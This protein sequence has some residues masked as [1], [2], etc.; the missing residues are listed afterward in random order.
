[1]RRLHPV[2]RLV[3]AAGVEALRSRRG[4]S[5]LPPFDPASRL[6]TDDPATSPNSSRSDWTRERPVFSS[7]IP[8]FPALAALLLS[9][10]T[11]FADV[12][13]TQSPFDGWNDAVHLDNGKVETVVVPSIG[14]VM[15]FRLKA[16][17]NVFWENE[18]MRG[19]GMPANP[20]ST[21]G[22]F[23]GDK[24][25]PS[26]QSVWNWPPPDIFDATPLSVEIHGKSVELNSP[27]SPRFGIRT[28]RVIELDPSLPKMRIVTTYYKE[29]GPPVEVGV[30]IITQAREP[31]KVF[32]PIPANGIFPSGLAS[33]WELPAKF[34]KIE[35]GMVSLSR[36]PGGSHKIGNDAGSIAWVGKDCV[37]RIDAPRTPGAKYPD[38]GCSMELYTNLDPARYVELETLGPLK[39]MKP[40]DTL[41]ATN[42]YTL[43]QRTE[44]DPA[45]AAKA[46]LQA[47]P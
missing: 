18:S 19:H 8:K 2:E 29:S 23:G 11:A 44:K 7:T 33:Q 5:A 35:S 45:A 40:G 38:E 6:V 9:Y 34:G 16:Q 14:R 1:M 37:L 47:T 28:K 39:T 17:E 13:V 22:S 31:E 30:W 21:A 27:V 3:K 46:A 36:D 26:P 4:D 42:T 41:S 43:F 32:I 25:W 20:W 12:T 24:T 15:Q 10:T